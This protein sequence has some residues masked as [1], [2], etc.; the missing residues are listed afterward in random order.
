[1]A[2]RLLLGLTILLLA[3]LSV[4][5]LARLGGAAPWARTFD[6]VDFYCAGE[7]LN[8]GRDPYRY[9]PLRTC[10]HRNADGLRI[11]ES[12]AL[13]VPAPLPPYDLSAYRALATLPFRSVRAIDIAGTLVILCASVVALGAAGIA[14]EVA[15]LALV[16]PI[17]Y[18]ELASGEIAP[19]AFLA[20]AICGCALVKRR[21]GVAGIFGA[22]MAIEPHV[23]LPVCLALLLFVPRAR[24]GMVLTLAALGGIAV[25]TVGFGGIREYVVAVLPA[26]ALAEVVNPQQYSVTWL[27]W[28]LGVKRSHAVLLGTV[29]YVL[30]ALV[31][32]YGASL[33]RNDSCTD[34]ALLAFVPAACA[35]AGGTFVHAEELF[36]AIPAA[37]VFATQRAGPMRAVAAAALCALA[38]PW[39]ALWSVKRLF[40]ASMLVCVLLLWRLGIRL[41]PALATLIPIGALVYAFEQRPPELHIA[42]PPSAY[43]PP[44]AIVQGEW[45]DVMNALQ[46]HD[47]LWLAI[48]IPTW[49]ALATVI[50][51][52]ANP[53]RGTA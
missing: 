44:D 32:I 41:A 34:R 42:L 8:A 4:R 20:L 33:R 3:I 14:L 1:M 15:L 50:S 12:A 36:F 22:L 19:L 29:A 28:F 37:L 39:L 52:A 11:Y 26:H 31:G 38:I 2:P 48:K 16:L 21:D 6:L 10:E 30:V 27:A 17:G 43:Y 53:R 24:I 23:A 13:A 25:L 5:D 40:A 18:V 46:T 35:V 47:P 9:E 51:L 49:V 7:A 45:T